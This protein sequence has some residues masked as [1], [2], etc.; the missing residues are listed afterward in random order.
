MSWRLILVQ[1][2]I[3]VFGVFSRAVK[4]KS[5]MF[6]QRIDG[7]TPPSACKAVPFVPMKAGW[8]QKSNQC[9][10]SP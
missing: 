2:P 9:G 1:V 3:S 6:E 8:S 10:T 5:K 4:R 7:T